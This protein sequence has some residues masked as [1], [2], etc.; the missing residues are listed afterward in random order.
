MT[1]LAK[2]AYNMRNKR[3]LWIDLIRTKHKKE[4]KGEGNEMKIDFI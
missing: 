1:Y 3:M 2:L 4:K